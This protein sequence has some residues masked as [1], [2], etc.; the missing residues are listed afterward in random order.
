MSDGLD[1]AYRRV[2]AA[3]LL[4]AVNDAQGGPR[5]REARRFLAGDQAAVLAAGLGLDDLTLLDWVESLPEVEL[6][7]SEH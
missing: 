2:A 5:V 3:C 1:R 4:R 6:A 7:Q